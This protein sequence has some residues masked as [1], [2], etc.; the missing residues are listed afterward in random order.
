[1][2]SNVASRESPISGGFVRKINEENVL[3]FVH[4]PAMFDEII[5]QTHGECLLLSL[6]EGGAPNRKMSKLTVMDPTCSMYGIFT[7]MTG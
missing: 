7:Y 1:M 2:P 3:R 6:S 5:C 4:F